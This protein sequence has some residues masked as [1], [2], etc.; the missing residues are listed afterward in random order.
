MKFQRSL[1]YFDNVTDTDSCH[2]NESAF[3]G[4]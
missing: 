1:L 4:I 2:D 3:T